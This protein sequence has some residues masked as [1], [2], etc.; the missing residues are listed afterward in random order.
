M[1]FEQ[2]PISNPPGLANACK[3]MTIDETIPLLDLYRHAGGTLYKQTKTEVYRVS[4][5]P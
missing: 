3:Y 5:M 1:R 4:M 2:I